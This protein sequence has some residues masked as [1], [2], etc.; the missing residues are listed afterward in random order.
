MLRSFS[1]FLLHSVTSFWASCSHSR[2]VRDRGFPFAV[3]IRSLR[4]EVWGAVA[5]VSSANP[6]AFQK[7]LVLHFKV[8][9]LCREAIT[10]AKPHGQLSLPARVVCYTLNDRPTPRFNVTHRVPWPSRHHSRGACACQLYSVWRCYV[11]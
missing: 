8:A 5:G 2:W 11:C 3:F 1:S 6:A 7:V 9:R 4:L 10:V